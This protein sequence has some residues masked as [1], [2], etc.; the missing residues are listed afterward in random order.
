MNRLRRNGSARASRLL[1]NAPKREALWNVC[2]I[3]SLRS[4]VADLP[5]NV[6]QQPLQPCVY[7]AV[8]HRLYRLLT[9]SLERIILSE[10]KDL[11]LRMLVI[12]QILRSRKS[13]RPQD[14]TSDFPAVLRWKASHSV[15]R[16]RLS[17]FVIHLPTAGRPLQ[18]TLLSAPSRL[19]TRCRRNA[20][21]PET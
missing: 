19:K 8:Q 17:L 3:I 21:A 10:A 4:N 13:A 9:K 7:A 16:D 5:A 20:R 2:G 18:S 6:F 1:K 15:M 11:L 12:K 14:D